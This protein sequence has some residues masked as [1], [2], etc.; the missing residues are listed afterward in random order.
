[1]KKLLGIVL[2]LVLLFIFFR[3]PSHSFPKIIWSYWDNPH[4]LP[5]TVKL[6]I[7]SW[8]KHNPSYTIVLMNQATYK[9]YVDIPSEVANHPNLNDFP[10]RFADLVRICC[11]AK[12]GGVWVDSSTLMTQPLDSF[13]QPA[14]FQGFTIGE[15]KPTPV[16][17]NWFFACVKGSSF[18][19]LW[20]DEFLQLASY[21]SNQHYLDSRKDMGVD[22]ANVSNPS[23]LT[24]H[25]AAQKVLQKN[26]Y[27]LTQF[28][29]QRSEYGPFK[30]LVDSNWDS[31]KGLE[32]A[33]K[34]PSYRKP[35]LKLRGADRKVFG[36]GNP[37]LTN[38]RCGWV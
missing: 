2:F 34:D 7:Q 26:K 30:Y 13:L 37:A 38:D 14:E 35:F 5:E 4:T 6:C 36:E 25:V 17:E 28:V 29:L 32:L 27:P 12:H 9:D 10:A 11:L 21:S 20:R 15:S 8:Q 24:M 23:Y 16:I 33:C 3:R 31:K 22:Y 18:M 19:K 1:M